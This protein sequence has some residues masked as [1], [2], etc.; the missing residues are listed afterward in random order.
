[1]ELPLLTE[2]GKER[3]ISLLEEASLDSSYRYSYQR[4]IVYEVEGTVAGVAFGYLSQ[5]EKNIDQAWT[6]IL[7]KYDLPAEYQLFTEQETMGEEWYL[8]TLAVAPEF[9]GKGIGT[10]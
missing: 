3:V 6:K 4:A 9:R 2:L 8:D 7:Q 5:E 1:M 10:K